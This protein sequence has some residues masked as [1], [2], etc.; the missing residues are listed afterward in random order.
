MSDDTIIEDSRVFGRKYPEEPCPSQLRNDRCPEYHYQTQKIT[1]SFKG[2]Y[3]V[4][5]SGG[6]PIDFNNNLELNDKKIASLKKQ[7]W[8]DQDT[9][10]V[11]VLWT[12]YS[13]WSKTFFTFQANLEMPGNGKVYSSG[14]HVSSLFFYDGKYLDNTTMSLQAETIDKVEDGE[15]DSPAEEKSVSNNNEVIIHSILL[16]HS[17]LYLMKI[18][19]ELSLGI[20][21]IINFLELINLGAMFIVVITKYV[22]IFLKNQKIDLSNFDTFYTW[23]LL[24]LVSLEEVNCI[25][26]AICSF[27]YPFRIF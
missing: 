14:F 27:F 4:Y 3:G 5:E 24:I 2:K 23:D 13:V 12:V 7:E 6:F 8:I 22:E 25:S 21:R 1:Q 16:I 10:A 26:L 19:F 17:L 9:R 20:S 18:L 11:Q 15:K